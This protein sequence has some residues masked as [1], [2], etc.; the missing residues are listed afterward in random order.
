LHIPPPFKK[1]LPSR[2]VYGSVFSRKVSR[3]Y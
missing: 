1:D 2:P 3:H